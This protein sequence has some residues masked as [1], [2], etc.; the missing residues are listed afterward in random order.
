MG[1]GLAA[2]DSYSG[3]ENVYGGRR[4]DR[5]TGSDAD[6]LLSGG[7]G[8]DVLFG[9]GGNDT[10][11]G[12]VGVDKMTG[13]AGN[14]VFILYAPP[15]GAA[16]VI[17]DFSNKVDNNDTIQISVYGFGGG[18]SAGPLA[19]SQFRS[20]KDHIAQDADDRFIFDKTDKSLWFDVDGNGSAAALKILDLQDSATF[21]VADLLLI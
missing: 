7:Q 8:N 18:L 14:D 12:D 19:P 9:G 16:D 17:T 3:I 11:V 21:S 20:R 15:T 6:N 1:T 5:V 4:N 13:G 2:G 10:L